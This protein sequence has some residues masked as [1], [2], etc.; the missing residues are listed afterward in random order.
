MLYTIA[1]I[2]CITYI[3]LL[4]WLY[5][6]WQIN[7]SDSPS[8]SLGRNYSILVPVRNEAANI[9]RCL[10]SLLHQ[11]YSSEYEVILINDHSEDD[12]LLKARSFSQ[13]II[14][15]LD[16][17]TTGKKKAIAQG[18]L[19][20]KHDNII[21]VDGDCEVGPD[22][23]AT[24][25]KSIDKETYLATAIVDVRPVNSTTSAFEYYDTVA[26]MA[27]TN[28][29]INQ[30][31]FY[32]AN[33]CNLYFKKQLFNQ[34]ASDPAYQ[35]YQSGD[36][37]FLIKKAVE[38]GKKVAFINNNDAIAFTL[39]QK[40]LRSLIRQRKRWST[41]TKG[42]ANANLLLLQGFIWAYAIV[43]SGLIFSGFY[44]FTFWA[45]GTGMLLVKILADYIFFKAVAQV[46]DIVLKHYLSSS[47]LYIFMIILMGFYALFPSKYNWKG[48]QQT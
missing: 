18:V 29:G 11:K 7:E 24:V 2:F 6:I 45:F 20:A 46:N 33:G 47:I 35:K 28:L 31:L 37:V 23:L 17:E 30:S 36:D 15:D 39:P 26:T 1:C 21:T 22:W 38:L 5:S 25:D 10:I 3:S 14:I 43:T 13:V 19:R 34:A 27:A 12:T 48:R 44:N 9:E 41:K 32:L 8:I 40:N 4:Y 42:Y 16:S